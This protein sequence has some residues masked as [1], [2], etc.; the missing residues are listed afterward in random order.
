MQIRGSQIQ[1]LALFA[2][3][4]AGIG[5][6]LTGCTKPAPGV[7]V[8]SGTQ[9]QNS[10]AICWSFDSDNLTPAQCASDLIANAAANGKAPIVHVIPG[11]TIGISVDTAVAEAGWT[12]IIGGQRLV[13]TPLTTNY[14]RFDWPSTQQIPA[15]GVE[16]IIQAGQDTKT[17]G[18]WAFKIAGS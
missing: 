3:G 15:S 8:F 9:T 11:D 12:P 16:L 1:R 7:S 13:E 18:I 2:V 10:E 6:A 17:R 5:L 14:W 4:A